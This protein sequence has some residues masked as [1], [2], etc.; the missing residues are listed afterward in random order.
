MGRNKAGE[1]S[2]SMM[3]LKGHGH[4][5][6]LHF[7]E[8]EQSLKHFKQGYNMIIFTL[9]KG[10]SA[11]LENGWRLRMGKTQKHGSQRGDSCSDLRAS[12]EQSR[13]NGEREMIS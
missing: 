3:T 4:K 7:V 6:G 11:S 12:F 13:K 8:K 2:M 9:Q 10:N 1:K 5:F